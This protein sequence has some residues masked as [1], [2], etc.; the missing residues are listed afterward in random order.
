M[1]DAQT[2]GLVGAI[3][4]L[5]LVINVALLPTNILVSSLYAVPVLVAAI[6]LRPPGGGRGWPAGDPVL[7]D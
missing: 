5:A 4:L 2:L 3:L 7:L 6:R 1:R